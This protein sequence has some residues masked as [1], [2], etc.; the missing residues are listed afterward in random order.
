MGTA[1]PTHGF[2][3]GCCIAP[4]KQALTQ[5]SETAPSQ[6]SFIGQRLRQPD[7]ISK[8]LKKPPPEISPRVAHRILNL[9]PLECGPPP[10]WP[11]NAGQIIKVSPW[12]CLHR[13]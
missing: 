3:Y 8:A 4:F 2:T 7:P 10:Y 12:Q 6:F 13:N 11:L 5:K 1:P 9:G